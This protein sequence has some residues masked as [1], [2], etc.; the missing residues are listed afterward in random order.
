MTIVVDA[1]VSLGKFPS[2]ALQR[3]IDHLIGFLPISEQ[4]IKYF[5]ITPGLFYWKA[6]DFAYICNT[7]ALI[8]E[9]IVHLIF[10]TNTRLDN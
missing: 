6:K 1:I 8:H 4:S 2:F 9:E 5:C 10:R 3:C 7:K